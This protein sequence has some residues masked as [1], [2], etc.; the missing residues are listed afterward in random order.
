MNKAIP[1]GLVALALRHLQQHGC[2]AD[3]PGATS[4]RYA[5]WTLFAIAEKCSQLLIDARDD[6]ALRKT[7]Y[8]KGQSALSVPAH[9]RITSAVCVAGSG[10]LS[11][12][13]WLSYL[14]GSDSGSAVRISV[15]LSLRY[16]FFGAECMVRCAAGSAQ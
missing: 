1:I 5:A 3:T 4:P 7:I 8:E 6:E 12:W 9:T 16:C 10:V 2:A 15:W 13:L 14:A 11:G